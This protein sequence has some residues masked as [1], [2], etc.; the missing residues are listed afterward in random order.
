MDGKDKHNL[1]DSLS[2]IFQDTGVMHKLH[3][4][5]AP[6]MAGRKTLLSKQARKEGINLKTIGANFPEKNYGED[7]VGKAKL[8]DSKIMVRKLFPLQLWCYAIEYYCDLSTMIIPGMFIN[9][10]RTGY[11]ILLRNTPDISEYV[12]F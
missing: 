1:V 10:G 7:V 5:N 3:T 11:E 2:L 9:K 12:E 4:K 8:G 6:K